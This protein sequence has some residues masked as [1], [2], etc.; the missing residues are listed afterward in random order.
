MF[1]SPGLIFLANSLQKKIN[2]KFQSWHSLLEQEPSSVAPGKRSS[3]YYDI[4]FWAPCYGS[5][6]YK[7][8]KSGL[9]ILSTG[10]GTDN[11]VL[12]SF[13]SSKNRGNVQALFSTCA[14]N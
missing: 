8:V 5:A 11:I 3:V 14:S 9:Y 1:L 4:S 2:I 10:V 7:G 12:Q 13:I 6:L